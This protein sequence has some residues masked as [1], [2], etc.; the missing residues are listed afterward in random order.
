MKN[1]KSL[2]PFFAIV[3]GLGLVFTQSAFKSGVKK[4]TLM[5]QYQD[6]DD[7]R[8]NDEAAWEDV[9]S[10]PAESCGEGSTL[11]CIVSFDTTEY[12]DLAAYLAAHPTVDDI[13][14]DEDNVVSKKPGVINP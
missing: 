9:T 2:L 6:A 14:L 13:L 4:T 8:I 11:P 10:E 3:L 1:S 5:F 7:D 12:A